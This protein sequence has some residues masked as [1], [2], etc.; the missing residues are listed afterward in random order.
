MKKRLIVTLAGLLTLGVMAPAATGW[1]R[2]WAEL[3]EER[4]T[5]NDTGSNSQGVEWTLAEGSIGITDK[6]AVTFDVEKNYDNIT[7]GKDLETYWDNRFGFSYDLGKSG[8][9]DL[10]TGIDYYYDTNGSDDVTKSQY[11]PWFEASTA[12]TDNTK[13]TFWGAMYY[14]DGNANQYD[15]DGNKTGK[16]HG[17]DYELDILLDTGKVAFFDYT[18]TWLYLYHNTSG[19]SGSNESTSAELEAEAFTT[20]YTHDSGVYAGIEYYFDGEA[21]DKAEEWMD[22]HIGPRIGYSTKLD[23]GVTAWVYTSYE[24]LSVNYKEGGD[25]YSDNEFQVVAGLKATF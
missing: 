22:S 4:P 3:T 12:L 23:D 8:D 24:V 18:G 6:L 10:S 1:I 20:V 2:N 21:G 11:S 19:G 9:W 5:N 14:N 25:W 15:D 16:V 13:L 7:N 17:D